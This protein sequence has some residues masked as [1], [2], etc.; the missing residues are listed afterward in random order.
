[1]AR[2]ERDITSSAFTVT[3][4]TE[5]LSLSGTESTAANIAATLATVINELINQGILSGSV[6]T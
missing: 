6:S 4:F 1:M 3:N 5:D 2:S